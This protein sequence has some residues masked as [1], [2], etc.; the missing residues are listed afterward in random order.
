MI[1]RKVSDGQFETLAN[2]FKNM[3]GRIQDVIGYMEKEEFCY[4]LGLIDSTERE[5]MV[6]IG[7]KT[8]Q[9]TSEV[10]LGTLTALAPGVV[11]FDHEGHSHSGF[12]ERVT[13]NVCKFQCRTFHD[14]SALSF[15]PAWYPAGANEFHLA[16][17]YFDFQTIVGSG[18]ES[19]HKYAIGQDRWTVMEAWLNRWLPGNGVENE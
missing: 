16:A 18:L 1:I 8:D 4:E 5:T 12:L 7:S 9:R 15:W 14:K 3:R 17:V 10:F 6:L 11:I 13:N 2:V 19:R